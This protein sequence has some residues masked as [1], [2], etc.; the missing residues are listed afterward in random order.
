MHIDDGGLSMT[1]PVADS[2]RAFS[3][4]YENFAIR[5]SLWI[6]A[7]GIAGS[8]AARVLFPPA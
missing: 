5:M 7:G 8:F 4:A 1:H 3:R 2:L 6:L